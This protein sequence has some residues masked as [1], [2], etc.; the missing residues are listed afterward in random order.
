M[1]PGL[2]RALSEDPTDNALWRLFILTSMSTTYFIAALV[3]IWR[4]TPLWD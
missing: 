4:G 2:I 3:W 1:R